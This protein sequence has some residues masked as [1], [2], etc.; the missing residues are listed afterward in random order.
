MGRGCEVGRY[1]LGG[2]GARGAH[3][4][5]TWGARGRRYFADIGW[6]IGVNFGWGWEFS[7]GPLLN[8]RRESSRGG[9][10]GHWVRQ[11]K[12]V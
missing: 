10:E 5:R 6:G 11:S 4:G 2:W 12:G 3:V 7:H 8:P 9:S 1:L